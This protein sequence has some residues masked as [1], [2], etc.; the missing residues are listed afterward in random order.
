MK[1]QRKNMKKTF[2]KNLNMVIITKRKKLLRLRS[3]RNNQDMR[4]MRNWARSKRRLRR[5]DK[6][7][8]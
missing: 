7:L 6:G 1:K 5:R 2:K 8:K 4:G 3:Q